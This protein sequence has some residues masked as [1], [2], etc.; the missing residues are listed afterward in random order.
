MS[1]ADTP[2]SAGPHVEVSFQSKAVLL[3]RDAARTER[4]AVASRSTTRR[5]VF[6]VAP[7]TRIG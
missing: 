1:A 5:P 3:E 4:P 6:P 2:E 7:M